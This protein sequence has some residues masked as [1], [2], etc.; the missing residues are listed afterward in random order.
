M[1]DTVLKRIRNGLGF[2]ARVALTA[3]FAAEAA[4]ILTANAPLYTHEYKKPDAKH[5][6]AHALEAFHA[7]STLELEDSGVSNEAAA[8][9][10][11]ESKVTPQ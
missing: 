3:P 10:D 4:E 2:K 7:C 1:S 5:T 11:P 8:T 6:M 9:A